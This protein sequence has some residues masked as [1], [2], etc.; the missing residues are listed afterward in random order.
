MCKN[1]Y[2]GYLDKCSTIT[3]F[4]RKFSPKISPLLLATFSNKNVS[5]IYSY[6]SGGENIE[7]L[8]AKK[9][10][11]IQRRMVAVA[12]WLLAVIVSVAALLSSTPRVEAPSAAIG[13]VPSQISRVGF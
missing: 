10:T 2:L 9:M 6:T 5:A 8:F 4:V 13:T 11:H 12:V 3:Y 7:N 1:I